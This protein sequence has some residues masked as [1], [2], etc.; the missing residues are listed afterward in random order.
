MPSF[1]NFRICNK[2]WPEFRI[3]TE[4]CKNYIE[5]RDFFVHNLY[6]PHKQNSNGYFYGIG[7]R[8]ALPTSIFIRLLLC[9]CHTKRNVNTSENMPQPRDSLPSDM[10][11]TWLKKCL[12][13]YIQHTHYF[14]FLIS[15]FPPTRPP[16]VVR[17]QLKRSAE[18][19]SFTI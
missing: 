17:V 15:N 8:Y 14:L 4:W 19:N 1:I 18:T 16:G 2:N 3:K 12:L 5:T 6:L 11:E 7:Y 10:L 9:Y 13:G